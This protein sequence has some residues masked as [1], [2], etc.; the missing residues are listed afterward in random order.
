MTTDGRL[1]NGLMVAG[2]SDSLTLRQ[3][4]GRELTL[5][6]ADIQELTLSSKSLIPEGIERDVTI[7]QMADVLEFLKSR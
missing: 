7:E 3:P 1:F 6:R 2:S 5:V 4:E